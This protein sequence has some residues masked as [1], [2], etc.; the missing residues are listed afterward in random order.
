MNMRINV[1]EK[2]QKAMEAMMPLGQYL[3]QST[4]DQALLKLIYF[5]VSQINGCAMCLDMHSKELKAL[6]EKGQRLY[7]LDAWRS[8]PFYSDQE[9]AALA[10][11]ESLTRLPGGGELVPDE[12][13]DQAR[14]QFTETE[15]IELTMAVITINSYNR[16]NL[17]FDAPVG[18]YQ[19]GAYA[20]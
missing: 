5:R 14:D 10:Y 13:F 20:Q 11:A 7:T 12:I 18:S 15:M 6:G 16:I 2:G 8:A 1:F 4:I 19:V 17:A 3:A 9:K